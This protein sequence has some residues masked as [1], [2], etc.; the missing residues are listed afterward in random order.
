MHAWYAVLY[1]YLCLKYFEL[2]VV[3]CLTA[4]SSKAHVCIV[5]QL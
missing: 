4:P 1:F 3:L 2:D 5:T